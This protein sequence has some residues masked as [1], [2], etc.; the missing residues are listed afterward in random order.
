MIIN[1]ESLIEGLI[2]PI[3]KPLNWTSFD[4]VKKLRGNFKKTFNIKKIKVGHAGTLDPLATG[5][6]LIC[7][8]KKTK[9]IEDLQNLDKTYLAT[10]DFGKTTP[11]FDRETDFN[12]NYPT[13]HITEELV[14]KNLKYFQGKIKQKPPIYSALKFNGKR[15]YEIAR[16]GKTIDIEYREVFV[17]EFDM[18][19]SNFPE[20]D[21]KIKCSKGTYIRSLAND[22]GKKLKSGAYLK[23]LERYSIGEY[24]INKSLTIESVSKLISNQ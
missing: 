3:F 14:V 11:S 24:S 23:Y 15:M 16:K 21:F 17:H 19:N 7:T 9:I 2:I 13:D 8:G 10:F 5:L 12:K 6:L 18:L 20:F 1:K 22:F 4:V